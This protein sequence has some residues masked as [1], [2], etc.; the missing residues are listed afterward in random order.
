[1][2]PFE[3]TRRSRRTCGA[4]T[5]E[6]QGAPMEGSDANDIGGVRIAVD[7]K[8]YVIKVPAMR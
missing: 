4:F 2:S 6:L 1:M 3:E 8:E 7:G 5:K